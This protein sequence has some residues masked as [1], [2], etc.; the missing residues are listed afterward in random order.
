V[1]GSG[2]PTT[3]LNSISLKFVGQPGIS[4]LNNN[5]FRL[6][7]NLNG[8]IRGPTPLAMG[9]TTVLPALQAVISGSRSNL[10]TINTDVVQS[11]RCMLIFDNGATGNG[12][13]GPTNSF[14]FD[15]LGTGSSSGYAL[16][17][18]GTLGS[19][20]GQ[21]SQSNVTFLAPISAQFKGK[22]KGQ[23]V[24]GSINSGQINAGLVQ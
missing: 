6:V 18:S 5:P 2:L 24:S 4:P 16:L 3:T 17:T 12:S 8:V 9:G 13:I 10:V 19:Y 22:I 1:D 23:V 15:I 11:Q 20:R 14:K 7:G 21:N